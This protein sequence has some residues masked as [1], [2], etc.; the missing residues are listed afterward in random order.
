MRHASSQCSLRKNREQR[1]A[2]ALASGSACRQILRVLPPAAAPP[3]AL[4][5]PS[6]R[7][8]ALAMLAGR[9]PLGGTRE[10]A[11][12]AFLAARLADDARPQRGLDQEARAVRATAARSWLASLSLPS[13]VKTALGRLM[14]ATATGPE[15]TLKAL[16]QVIA[17]I[18]DLLDAPSRAE[19]EALARS[20]RS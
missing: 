15:G 20:L 10:V 18:G 16:T 3:Y 2:S 14:D 5:S 11:L 6:F 1:T 19:L 17:A 9:A 4:S 7:F 13:A 12:A 8:R